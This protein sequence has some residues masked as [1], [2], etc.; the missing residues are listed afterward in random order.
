M[1]GDAAKNQ[2]SNNPRRTIFDIKRIIGSKFTDKNIQADLKHF[3]FKVVG[4]DGQPRVKI[5]VKG[6][7]T[8]SPSEENG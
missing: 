1:V 5:D 3:P 2:F 8:I 4:K 7:P 6:T